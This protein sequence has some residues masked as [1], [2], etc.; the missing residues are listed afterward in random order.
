MSTIDPNEIVPRLRRK[1]TQMHDTVFITESSFGTGVD[2]DLL[3][4]KR[5]KRRRLKHR[6]WMRRQQRRYQTL[7][8]DV[9]H[10]FGT[11]AQLRQPYADRLARQY[12]LGIIWHRELRRCTAQLYIVRARLGR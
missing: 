10:A 8:A 2:L 3:A 5:R 1:L 9:H 4:Y 7:V 6:R 12:Q 11:L